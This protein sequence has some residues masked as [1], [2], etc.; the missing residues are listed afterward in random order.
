MIVVLHT[1]KLM[2]TNDDQTNN[3]EKIFEMDW[4]EDQHKLWITLNSLYI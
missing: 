1:E 2:A 4:F 3:S